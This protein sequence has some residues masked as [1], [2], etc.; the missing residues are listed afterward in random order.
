MPTLFPGKIY[1][2]RLKLEEA[3]PCVKDFNYEFRDLY[4]GAKVCHYFTFSV[5]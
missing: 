4:R 1:K 5:F 3:K 2:D